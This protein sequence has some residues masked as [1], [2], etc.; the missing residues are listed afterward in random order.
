VQVLSSLLGT[1]VEWGLLPY[2]PAMRLRLPKA[3]P[4]PKAAQQ[5]LTPAQVE[6]LIAHAGSL[7]NETLIRVAVQ[8]GLRR[9]ALI[10]LRWSDLRLGERRIELARS[11]WQ[12]RGG[13]RV[14]R[15]A[16]TAGRSGSPCPRA[17]PSASQR[18]TRPA[19]ST[20]AP[21][22]TGSCGRTRVAR[23]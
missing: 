15:P 4:K 21:T 22:R 20:V 10:G 23:R 6:R 17:W 13:R 12:G 1:A 16:S 5:V 18:G 14:E 19:S 2:N 11:I 9:G 8:V 7:R 3:P